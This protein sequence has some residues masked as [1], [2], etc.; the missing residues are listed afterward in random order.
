MPRLGGAG[1]ELCKNYDAPLSL[2]ILSREF[3]WETGGVESGNSG[4]KRA[5]AVTVLNHSGRKG[6]PFY[7]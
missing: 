4:A 3:L 6:A 1:N 2:F 5:L 7:A